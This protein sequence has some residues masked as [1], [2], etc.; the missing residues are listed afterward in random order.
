MDLL[1]GEGIEALIQSVHI[2][3]TDGR[4]PAQI[5]WQNHYPPR[6]IWIPSH[7]RARRQAEDPAFDVRFRS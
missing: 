1:R 7:P 4:R 3:C 5:T 6:C 2:T